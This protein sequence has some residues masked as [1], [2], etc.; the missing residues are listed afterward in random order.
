M[1][2]ETAN[3]GSACQQCATGKARCVRTPEGAS[4]CER[5]KRLS[6][7]CQPAAKRRKLK[8]DNAQLGAGVGKNV[9]ASGQASR[10]ERKLD[11]LVSLLR[12]P[13]EGPLLQATSS[14]AQIISEGS[15]GSQLAE[16][17]VLEPSFQEAQECL[18]TFVEGN[19][20]YFPF[21]RSP[22]GTTASQLRQDRPLLW[23]AIMSIA[24]RS[25]MRQRTRAEHL[26]Q[27][28]VEQIFRRTEH[29]IDLLL[30]ILAYIAWYAPTHVGSLA[31]ICG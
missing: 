20:K 25:T 24:S 21:Y 6:K 19:L 8:A 10:V 11:E 31:I 26:R 4:Q 29:T 3:Y 12:R 18:T 7:D 15:I 17:A 2:D 22:P 28:M 5:C 1:P 16:Q 9:S 14:A 30:A 23:L 27:I 13:S